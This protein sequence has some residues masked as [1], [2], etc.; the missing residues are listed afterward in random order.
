MVSSGVKVL[1]TMTCPY[2]NRVEIALNLKSVDYKFLEETFPTKSELLLQSNPVHKKI[3]V[4]IH[5]EKLISESLIIV[6]YIDG[7]WT[8]GPS[9]LPLDP[10]DRATAQFWAA[11]VDDKVCS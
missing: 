1:G 8:G 10:Y 11:Y 7:A 2:A 3:P 5:G 4:M 6:Q 9:I